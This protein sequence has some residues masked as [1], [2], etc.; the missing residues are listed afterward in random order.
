MAASGD[1]QFELALVPDP[2]PTPAVPTPTGSPAMSTAP[3]PVPAAVSTPPAQAATAAAPSAAAPVRSAMPR[4]GA[5]APQSWAAT[6]TAGAAAGAARAEAATQRVAPAATRPVAPLAPTP[7]PA[8]APAPALTS[9]TPAATGSEPTAQPAVEVLKSPPL[10]TPVIEPVRLTRSMRRLRDFAQLLRLDRPIGTWL[11]V[12]P[13]LWA[14]WIAAEGHP[15]RRLLAIFIAGAVLMRSAGCIINDLA[16][17]NIDP[18]VKRT[19]ARP[20]AARTISPPEALTVFGVLV[21]AGLLLVLQLNALTLWLALAGAALTIT[22]PLFKRFFPL[23][24]LYL[25]LCFGWAVPMAFAATLGTVPRVGWL[26]LVAA[27]LWAGVY[28]TMYAMV[29]RDDDLRIGVRSSAILFADLDRF[30]IAA[31]QLM[32][33]F[34]LL[35]IGRTL[36]FGDGYSAGLI[37]GACCF[38]WQQWLIRNREPAAC[39]TAFQNNNYFGFAVFA[40]ILLQYSAR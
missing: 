25:G 37:A 23:P 16:D 31:M 18:H 27:V 20:L 17:R 26:M 11:L 3:E 24:Q 19:R 22:Y 1:Q 7:A 28:D 5:A 35:L 13:M 39:F 30:M 9:A 29:D 10:F 4:S 40:G 32:M 2:V 33:L 6:G 15:Q 21:A 34:S 8:P 12:W 14:L 38:L 36:K